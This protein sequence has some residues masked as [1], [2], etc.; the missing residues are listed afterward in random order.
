MWKL[1]QSAPSSGQP[2]E[3]C[4]EEWLKEVSKKCGIS[5]I[6]SPRLRRL[7]V[8]RMMYMRAT[9]RKIKGGR[10]RE[11]LLSKEWLLT[12]SRSE[13]V[14]PEVLI[15]DNAQLQDRV[16]E[17]QQTVDHQAGFIKGLQQPDGHRGRKCSL[18]EYSGRH[19][20]RLKKERTKSCNAALSWLEKEGVTPLKVWDTF[21][22]G[23]H[24][25][26]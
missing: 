3:K 21:E 13:A 14:F 17:L 9:L 23:M 20:Q 15:Q 19:Q 4:L 24:V 5:L 11:D 26:L 1:F 18:E 16:S 6:S 22:C 10:Q 7:L 2:S 8:N 12:N 25:M